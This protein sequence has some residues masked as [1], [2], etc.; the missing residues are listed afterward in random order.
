MS[1][2]IL[3]REGFV[4]YRNL[5]SVPAE[6]VPELQSLCDSRERE[7][8]NGSDVGMRGDGRRSQCWLIESCV[9]TFADDLRR[10]V[11]Q[12]SGFKQVGWKILRSRAGCAEQPA[13]MDCAPMPTIGDA[14]MPLEVLVAVMPKTRLHVWRRSIRLFTACALVEPILKETVELETGDAVLFRG[15]LVHAG[16]AYTRDHMRLHCHLDSLACPRGINQTYVVDRPHIDERIR[17][18]IL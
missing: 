15:D 16:A 18:A 10:A 5:V 11:T 3:H 4:V 7:L 2:E 6:V 9:P 13:H 17:T 12:L 1:S 14:Q 8:F